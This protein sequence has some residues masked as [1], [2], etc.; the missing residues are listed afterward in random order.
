MQWKL[1]FAQRLNRLGGCYTYPQLKQ[2]H[3]VCNEIML[4]KIENVKVIVHRQIPKGFEIKTLSISKKSDGYYV[5][6]N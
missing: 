4:S 1:C 6:L 5:T 3:F 2:H